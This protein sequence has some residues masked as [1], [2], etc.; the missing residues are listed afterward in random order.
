MVDRR[1]E[2]SPSKGNILELEL[3]LCDPYLK[4]DYLWGQT[5]SD[6]VSSR[7]PSLG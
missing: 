1:I 7:T 4:R 2:C 5:D 6:D 3:E